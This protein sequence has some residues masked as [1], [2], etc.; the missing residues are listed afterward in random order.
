MLRNSFAGQSANDSSARIRGAGV[1]RTLDLIG[2]AGRAFS[3]ATTSEGPFDWLNDPLRVSRRRKMSG[4]VAS[5]V[6]N[7]ALFAW[8]PMPVLLV[9]VM[10]NG[11]EWHMPL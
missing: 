10:K 9:V 5:I 3:V 4:H 7:D 1:P 8:R 2:V 6:Y 11:G